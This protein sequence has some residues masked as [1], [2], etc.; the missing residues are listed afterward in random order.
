MQASENL[1]V[2]EQKINEAEQKKIQLIL[3]YT[4][5]KILIQMN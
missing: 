5:A 4:T 2:K 1:T 3:M